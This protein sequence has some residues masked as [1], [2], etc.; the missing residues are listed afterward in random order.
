MCVGLKNKHKYQTNR[1]NNVQPWKLELKGL[2]KI[3]LSNSSYYVEAIT[4]ISGFQNNSG[5]NLIYFH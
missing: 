1:S 3:P 5:K 4:A 2:I